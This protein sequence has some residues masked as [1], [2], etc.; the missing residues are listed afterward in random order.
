MNQMDHLQVFD[1][2]L[3][4][5]SPLF[6]GSGKILSKKEYLFSPQEQQNRV[7]LLDET[8]FFRLLVQKG[9]LD[10][11]ESFAMGNK[12]DLWHFLV[13]TCRLTGTELE[14]SGAVRYELTVAQNVLGP[15]AMKELHTFQRDAQGRAYIPGS[16]LKGALRTAWIVHEMRSEPSGNKAG[17]SAAAFETA[18]D[19]AARKL[20]IQYTNRLIKTLRKRNDMLDS[21]FRGIQVADSSSIA[22]EQMV[23]TGR[24]LLSPKSASPQGDPKEL[25]M[26]Q[27]CVKPGTPIRFRVTLD[28]TILRRH[29][30]ALTQESL[31]E[32]IRDFDAFYAAVFEKRFPDASTLRDM[33]VLPQQ[34]HLFLG[35]GPGFFSKTLVY[36]YL[37]ERPGEALQWTQRYMQRKYYN[38]WTASSKHDSDCRLGISPHRMK[39]VRYEGKLYPAG[40]CT[41]A[42]LPVEIA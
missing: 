35:G 41:V 18:N 34:P 2:V 33:A 11:Y 39:A 13:N 26:C 38:K 20:E 3:T 15:Y 21:I 28:Q 4:P 25:G 40:Y 6:V 10:K 23:L 42:F 32:A 27:E 5:Q 24:T 17:R 14:G 8:K 19:S 37:E 36:P 29:T 22:N 7:K 30:H 16:S 9:L 1:I 12:D 31:L